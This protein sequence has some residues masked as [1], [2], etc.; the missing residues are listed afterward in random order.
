MPSFSFPAFDSHRGRRSGRQRD[1]LKNADAVSHECD[2][3][4][5]FRG[6]AIVGA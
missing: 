5:W 4:L 6:A 3:R 1:S 2:W